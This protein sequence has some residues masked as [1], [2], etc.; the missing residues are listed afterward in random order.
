[1]SGFSW[2]IRNKVSM[3][4]KMAKRTREKSYLWIRIVINHY[5]AKREY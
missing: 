4:A 1:M 2:Y 3:M 5:G